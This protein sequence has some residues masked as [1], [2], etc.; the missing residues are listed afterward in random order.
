MSFYWL[1]PCDEVGRTCDRRL[2]ALGDIELDSAEK[3]KRFL[4][5]E[6]GTQHGSRIEL[7]L[8]SAGG[9]M[10][11][12]LRLGETI[13]AL[14]MDTCVEADYPPH[15]RDGVASTRSEAGRPVMCAS[16]CVF[17][18]AGGVHRSVSASARIGMHQ[19]TGGT[20]SSASVARKQQ[21]CSWS[22][23]SIR[24]AC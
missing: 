13:R 24:T 9:D 16:A 6:M 22:S 14:G 21:S 10:E 5:S 19:F 8:D 20:Q 17:A 2:L 18:L 23:I 1:A 12:A 11:G 4:R 3:L 15:S 7:C